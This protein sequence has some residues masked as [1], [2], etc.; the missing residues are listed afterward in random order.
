MKHKSL[1]L[2]CIALLTSC[3]AACHKTCTCHA[4]NGTEVEFSAEELDEIGRSC[5]EMEYYNY[6]LVYSYCEW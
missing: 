2:L 3:C 4:Y 6:G 1:I 5:Q